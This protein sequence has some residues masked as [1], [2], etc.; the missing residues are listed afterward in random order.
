MEQFLKQKIRTILPANP[1][2]SV[3]QRHLLGGAIVMLICLFMFSDAIPF[4]NKLFLNEIILGMGVIFALYLWLQELRFKKVLQLSNEPLIKA[5]KKL[6]HAE[7][8]TIATLILS[9]EAKDVYIRGHSKRVTQFAFAIAQEM[10]FPKKSQ[11]I[12][13][14]AGILHDI[15][16]QGISDDILNKPIKLSDKEWEQMKQHPGKS[17][18]ILK[19]LEFLSKEKEIILHHHE[20]YDGK[21]YPDGLS[22]ERIPLGARIMAVADSFDALNSERPYRESF[23]KEYIISTLRD[24]AGNQL[25]PSIVKIFI[26]LLE[27]NP[28]LWKKE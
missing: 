26:N 4:T 21:G 15:G 12:I 28:I 11:M 2:L 18:E 3:K 20:R 9:L 5:L 22:G 24:S 10:D 14:R 6:Q 13:V 7:I 19:P 17:I 25:D 23:S 1:Y 27:K 8:D 16:K